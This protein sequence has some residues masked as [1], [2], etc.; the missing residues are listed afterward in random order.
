M[1]F[2]KAFDMVCR[3]MMLKILK[4][5]GIPDS[6]VKAIAGVYK[7]PGHVYSLQMVP[8]SNFRYTLVS[9]RVIC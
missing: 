9:Y 3:G 1:D 8:Q 4:A 6:L 5:C 7:T 2:K